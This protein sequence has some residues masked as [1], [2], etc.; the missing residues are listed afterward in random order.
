MQDKE[1]VGAGALEEFNLVKARP[2]W[3]GVTSYRFQYRY[4][5]LPG[6][7]T[8]VQDGVKTIYA[9]E[10]LMTQEFELLD[11]ANSQCQ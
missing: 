7:L 4:Q 1:Q 8:V 2:L 10:Y 3:N 11:V 6:E 9:L 5:W